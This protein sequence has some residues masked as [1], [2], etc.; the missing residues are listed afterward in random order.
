MTARASGPPNRQHRTGY[1]VCGAPDGRPFSYHLVAHHM[2]ASTA[3]LAPHVP[4]PEASGARRGPRMAAAIVAFV[5]AA[6]GG[7]PP[8]T[9]RA[10]DDALASDSTLARDLTLAPEP[11]ANVAFADTLRRGGAAPADSGVL[12]REAIPRAAAPASRPAR[13]ERAVAAATPRP[14]APRERVPRPPTA[15]A[16]PSESVEVAERAP[17]AAPS[18]TPSAGGAANRGAIG[19][20]TLLGLITTARVCTST[21][22]PGDKII[23]TLDASS[24]GSG[25]FTLPA[26]TK[27]VVELAAVE[28]DAEGEP[29]GL[30]FR[31]RNLDD[32][33][34]AYPVTGEVTT[35]DSLRR[36]RSKGRGASDRQKVIGGAVL[37]AVLGQVIGKD[38]KGTVIGA[39]AGGAAGAAATVRGARYEGCLPEGARLQLRLL[40]PVVR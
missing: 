36:T 28:R 10:G 8:A 31:V 24:A 13:R 9:A 32:G 25:G 30:A 40:E 20:G 26:G 16:S 29:T 38:T 5:L 1:D 22:V 17:T 4:S 34:A 39:A 15:P 7:E 37:G 18:P 21:N 12:A 23:A 35:S 6:C 3:G 27:A 14:A 19:T 33:S 2:S 11:D